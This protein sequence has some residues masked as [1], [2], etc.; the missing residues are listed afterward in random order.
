MEVLLGPTL[1]SNANQGPPY[2]TVRTVDALK[3]KKLVLLYFSASW[4]PPCQAFTPI[5][6]NFHAQFAKSHKFEIVYISS[7][8]TP[9][10]FDAY[11]GAKMPHWL[12]FESQTT[13]SST[14]L[15]R[16]HLSKS[17]AI[18][19]IP[20]LVV[21]DATTG[22]FVTSDA[23]AHV[24]ATAGQTASSIAQSVIVEQ[25]QNGPRVPL[26]QVASAQQSASWDVVQ[27]LSQMVVKF[28]SNPA[29]I[30]GTV[31]L[32]QW[33]LRKYSNAKQPGGGAGDTGDDEAAPDA[34]SNA[35]DSNLDELIPDDEF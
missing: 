18:R 29:Y 19:G 3:G 13:P 12:A 17:L 33:V 25:W 1:W 6:V 20:T 9:A 21:L 5:L 4:C 30:I 35:R 14:A 24:M 31:Y 11:F 34:S 23:R 15:L 16:T 8:R 2:R 22:L 10:E 28:F 7:D 26:H 27:I 32:V